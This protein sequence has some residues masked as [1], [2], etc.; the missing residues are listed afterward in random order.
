MK[1]RGWKPNCPGSSEQEGPSLGGQAGPD[2]CISP[3]SVTGYG[4]PS[5]SKW[6]LRQGG[7]PQARQSHGLT[8]K[9]SIPAAGRIRPSFLR[10]N[11][12]SM[13]L[14]AQQRISNW[15]EGQEREERWREGRK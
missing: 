8:A 9:G 1:R 14:H 13:P 11:L 12:S 15:K 5:E 6:D 7:C 4:L 3:E 2:C 10:G